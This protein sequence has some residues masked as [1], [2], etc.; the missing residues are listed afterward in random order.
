MWGNKLV[1][2]HS[3]YYTTANINEFTYNKFEDKPQ[4]L[5]KAWKKLRMDLSYH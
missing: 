3:L 2:P 5:K 4:K 1:Y